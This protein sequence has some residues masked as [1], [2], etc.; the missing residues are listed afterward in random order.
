MVRGKARATGIRWS[1][2]L[3]SS[4]MS[5]AGGLVP[6]SFRE[7]KRDRDGLRAGGSGPERFQRRSRGPCLPGGHATA[8]TPLGT[9]LYTDL[10]YRVLTFSRP[11]YGH[12]GLGALTAAEFIPAIAEVCLQL[13]ITETAAT[14]GISFG[15]LQAVHVA[16]SLES[17]PR[18]GRWAHRH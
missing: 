18:P 14:V 13:G 12:T 3:R 8:A 2:A 9:D 17:A 5:V 15:G 1:T 11:G 6:S 7:D 4:V 10:G 16:V